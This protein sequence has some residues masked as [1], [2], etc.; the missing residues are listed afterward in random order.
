[1]RDQL[2]ESQLSREK[3]LGVV[4]GFLREES[5][6]LVG[7]CFL[8]GG[9]RWIFLHGMYTILVFWRRRLSPHLSF[10]VLVIE[11][12]LLFWREVWE[13]LDSGR[14]RLDPPF[15]WS[16]LCPARDFES[17]ES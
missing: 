5:A 9:K 10:F 6:Q 16:Y 15:H 7:F 2:Q 11:C 1:M 8:T 17:K 14:W 13:F 4:V 12:L 3:S